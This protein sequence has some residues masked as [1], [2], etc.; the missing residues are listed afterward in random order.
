MKVIQD[1]F[2]KGLLVVDLQVHLDSRGWFAEAFNKN[3]WEKVGLDPTIDQINFSTSREAGTFRGLHYQAD[4]Y[5]QTKTVFCVRGRIVDIVV[6]VRRD[7]PTYLKSFKIEL[8]P[9]IGTGIYVPPGFAHGWYSLE[10]DSQIMYLVKGA[11]S[12]EHERG[13]CFYDPAL[14]LELPGPVRVVQDRDREWP[15]IHP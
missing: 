15:L 4:P 14:K 6:D 7:S 5:A 12:K 10:Y 3:A 11:W 9:G 13:L 2:L 8:D 1:P